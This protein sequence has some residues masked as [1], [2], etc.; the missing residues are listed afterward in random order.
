MAIKFAPNWNQ[1]FRRYEIGHGNHQCDSVSR[2]I[3]TLYLE[4]TMKYLHTGIPTAEEKN[5]AGYVAPL[6]VHITSPDADPLGI[7]WL[8]FDADSSMHKDIQTKPHMAFQ[9]DDLDAAVAGKTI[10]HAPM[11]P[12]EGLRIAF[13]EQDGAVFELCQMG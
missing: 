8:K 6:G 13:I 10:L 7:E 5:W 12:M 1:I 11:S 4:K 9:V 3:F 2:K